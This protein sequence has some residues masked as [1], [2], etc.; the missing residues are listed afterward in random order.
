MSLVAALDEWVASLPPDWE[1]VEAVAELLDD[2]AFTQANL[3]MAR[4]NAG[5][6]REAPNGT[7]RVRINRTGGHGA[8][9]PA[10]RG[11]FA[12]IDRADIPMALRPTI[13]YSQRTYVQ[14]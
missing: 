2:S 5:R 1:Y 7:Y 6:P 8:A 14:P 10:V 4:I 9:L 12:A 11:T 13:S 3:L